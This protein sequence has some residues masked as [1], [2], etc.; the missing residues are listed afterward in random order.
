MFRR[1]MASRLQEYIETLEQNNVKIMSLEKVRQRLAGEVEDAQV[2][3]ER[4]INDDI[5]T[6]FN[7]LT[8]PHLCL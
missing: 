4:V 1:K 2:D 3:V 5:N 6:P 7:Y 8:S